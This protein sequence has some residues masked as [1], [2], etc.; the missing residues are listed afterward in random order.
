MSVQFYFYLQKKNIATALELDCAYV[1]PINF[2]SKIKDLFTASELV[3]MSV[4][5][6]FYLQNKGLIYALDLVLMSVQFHFIF[7]NKGLIYSLGT[8]AYVCPTYFNRY[9]LCSSGVAY[10]IKP[11]IR[12]TIIVF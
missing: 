1:C 10:A 9:C 4:Q 12:D 5:F 7:Q 3:L 8:S 11:D 6:Y 2:I